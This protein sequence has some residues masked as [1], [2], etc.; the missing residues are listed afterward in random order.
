M[1]EDEKRK[2]VL[3]LLARGKITI[4]E[5]VILLESRSIPQTSAAKE[6]KVPDEEV[7][8][9]VDVSLIDEDEP[10]V[11]LPVEELPLPKA[12]SSGAEPRW[13]R[14]FVSDLTT[15]KSKVKVNIPFGMVKFGMGVARVF[16]PEEYSSSLDGITELM[17]GADSGLLVDV[18][19]EEDNEHVRIYFD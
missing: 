6:E 3:E 16:T 12:K 5:A 9:K 7:S 17:A 15:G 14:I 4:D 1:S 2:E 10:D 18:Q 19:D 11:L 8:L 13:L